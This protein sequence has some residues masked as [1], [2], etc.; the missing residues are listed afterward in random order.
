MKSK[1]LA[2]NLVDG[3]GGHGLKQEVLEEIFSQHE[4]KLDDL[5]Y[6]FRKVFST[7]GSDFFSTQKID[8]E[9]PWELKFTKWHHIDDRWYPFWGFDKKDSGC[10]VY[11]LFYD[12]E[13]PEGSAN[14][15][16]SNVIYIG[17]SRASSRNAMLGRR[18]DF[19]SSVRNEPLA[20]YGCG[21]AFKK[22]FDK[23][24]IDN[25]WQAYLPMHSRFVK[26]HE[27]EML[28]EYYK[29]FGKVPICNPESDLRKV[30]IRMEKEKNRKKYEI[31][32]EKS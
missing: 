21:I 8:I 29:K 19:K 7:S 14:F 25:V 24:M 16:D 9:D 32:S 23:S 17:E 10:Y 20:P 15:L 31:L 27:M 30:K 1:I 2:K 13:V 12:D 22:H 4:D 11:G 18:N 6:T 5:C 26:N 3:S 28:I